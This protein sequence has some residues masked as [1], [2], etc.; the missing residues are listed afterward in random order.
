MERWDA[1]RALELIERHRV[2]TT[3]VVPTMF[4][5]MLRLP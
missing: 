5:R 1:M 4:V 2:T 3:Q